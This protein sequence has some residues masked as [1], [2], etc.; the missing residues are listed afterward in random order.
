MG[1]TAMVTGRPTDDQ[2]CRVDLVKEFVGQP[3]DDGDDEYWI[4]GQP[5]LVEI[6]DDG[7]SGHAVA[8]SELITVP[9]GFTTDGASIPE[10]V[11]RWTKWRPF[12]GPQRWAGITHDWLYYVDGFPR[13]RADQVFRA[14]LKSE[15]AS[16]LRRTLMYWAVRL[17][18]GKYYTRN[19]ARD[20]SSRIWNHDHPHDT[21]AE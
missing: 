6:L 17:Q 1:L 12:E 11:Q 9:V 5:L 15:G 10:N 4:L 21:T 3:V 13:K 2:F 8:N 14:V 16:W 20:I 7:A 18:G 19:Q